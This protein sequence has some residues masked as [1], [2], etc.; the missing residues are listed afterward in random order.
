MLTYNQSIN[1]KPFLVLIYCIGSE[2][3]SAHFRFR[4]RD[5]AID[6]AEAQF[7]RDR[8]YKVKV[9]DLRNGGPFQN[10]DEHPAMILHLV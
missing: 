1:K 2:G 9:W 3:K 5:R 6:F 10:V 4:H 7:L 8:V